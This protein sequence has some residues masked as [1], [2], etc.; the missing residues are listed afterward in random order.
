[1]LRAV[2]TRLLMFSCF[3][4]LAPP[5]LF[6]DEPAPE[7][8]N[9]KESYSIGYQVGVSMKTDGK[10]GK[11]DKENRDITDRL[12]MRLYSFIWQNCALVTLHLGRRRGTR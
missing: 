4:V 6:A 1:M 9:E 10:E 7:T 11:E 8:Q 3:W 2:S 5:H 12:I